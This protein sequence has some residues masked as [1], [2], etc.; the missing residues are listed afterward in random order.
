MLAWHFLRDDK[1]MQFRDGRR[2][3]DGEIVEAG[4]TYKAK[5]KLELCANGMHASLRAIDALEYA[6]G[7]VICRVELSGEI[8]DGGDKVC[9]RARKALW[10]ADATR[11]LHEF[12]C[13]CAEQALLREREAGREPDARS[14]AAIEAKRQWLAG[15]ISKGELDAARDAAWSAARDAAWSAARGAAWG[16]A[17]GAARGAAWSAAR[18]AAWDAAWGAA[19]GAARDTQNTELERMLNGLGPKEENVG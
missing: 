7:G 10:M 1:R 2:V 12:A 3:E 13:W 16:A 6:P 14:W 18:D 11:T 17:W 15:K 9:A 5:G 4:K 19:R 8:V